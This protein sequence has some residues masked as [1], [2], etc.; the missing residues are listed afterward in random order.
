MLSNPPDDE[1]LY[2]HTVHL[3]MNLNLKEEEKICHGVLKKSQNWLSIEIAA[4][5]NYFLCILPNP[6]IDVVKIAVE[7]VF[8]FAEIIQ[9]CWNMWIVGHLSYEV[10]V[11]TNCICLCTTMCDI[12][13]NLN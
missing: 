10:N 2:M 5:C 1:L 13:R 7:N 8:E 12:L 3:S 4:S 11:T 6:E 9:S